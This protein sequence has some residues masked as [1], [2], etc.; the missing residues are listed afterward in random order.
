LKRV[1][2]R[3]VRDMNVETSNH[4]FGDIYAER[5][6]T[7]YLIGVKTRNK[8]QV[9]G[10]LNP[11]YNIRK[12][13]A[14]VGSI[15]RRYNAILAW[16]AISVIPEQRT[17]NAYFGTIEQIEENG[18]RFS[19]PMRPKQTSNYECLS[20]I[21]EESDLSIRPEWSNGGYRAQSNIID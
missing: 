6:G 21:P 14:D 19:I 9:T 13:G 16:V 11:T 1:G 12:R 7:R 5:D 8:Y 15:A 10:L 18:E 4:P 17:F 20:R 2:F 3:D